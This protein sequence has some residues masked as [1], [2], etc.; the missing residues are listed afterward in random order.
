VN[1]KVGNDLLQEAKNDFLE[2]AVFIDGCI[3][4]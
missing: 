1:G 4:P 3:K 2:L